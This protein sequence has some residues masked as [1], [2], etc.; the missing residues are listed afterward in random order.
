MNSVCDL[1]NVDNGVVAE[2]PDCAI[3]CNEGYILEDNVC[4]K[5]NVPPVFGLFDVTHEIA[6]AGEFTIEIIATDDEVLEYSAENL[7]AG[8][9]LNGNIF[10]WTPGE[11][12]LGLF[13]FKF[14]VTDGEFTIEKTAKVEVFPNL[15]CDGIA[16]KK[17]YFG[18]DGHLFKYL[19][20]DKIFNSNPQVKFKD[21]NTGEH[22]ERV[23]GGNIDQAYFDFKFYGKKYNFVS[24][25][26]PSINDWDIMYKCNHA[27]VL[28]PI[29]NKKIKFD[30]E[31]VI[32]LSATDED[33]DPL[34][35]IVATMP[36]GA[37]L[38]GNIFTW[39]PTKDQIG[40]Y[41]VMFIVS[42]GE[43]EDSEVVKISEDLECDDIVKDNEYFVLDNILLQYKG[44][45]KNT[46][47]SPKIKFKNLNTGETLEY[48]VS[49]VNQQGSVT[50]KLGGKVYGFVSAS[51]TGVDDFDIMYKCG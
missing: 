31:L 45:D 26:D 30:Q 5:P 42:D 12:Q 36:V 13:Q 37:E 9:E 50:L 7:P 10:T 14:I 3:S 33:G 17:D 47:T 27:P 18:L 25:S 24:A 2:F 40:E 39:T 19:D 20:S 15:G 4:V 11:N 34:Q 21:I 28:D 41:H 48:S 51:D 23:I 8:A 22:I 44:A 6:V 32:E 1:Q 16:K 49:F 35:Y 46:D 43:L 38:N 29:G